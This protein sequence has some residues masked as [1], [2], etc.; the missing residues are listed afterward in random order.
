MNIEQLKYIVE[1]SKEES[2]T[3]AAKNLHISA[4]AVSQALREFE[5]RIN[6]KLFIR[7]KMKTVPTEAGKEI[8]NQAK[9]II[10]EFEILEEKIAIQNDTNQTQ[11]KIATP[12]GLVYL[13]NESIINFKKDFPKIDVQVYE[14]APDQVLSNIPVGQ[15]DI[16]FIFSDESKL[17][18]NKDV[19]YELLT[20]TKYCALVGKNSPL[21]NLD[22]VTPEDLLHENFVL[23]NTPS[24]VEHSRQI[25]KNMNIH[26][27]SNNTESIREAVKNGLGISFVRDITIKN[28]PDTFSGQLKSIP[29]KFSP[30]ISDELWT[31]YLKSKPLTKISKIFINYIQASIEN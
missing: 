15:P 27:I 21:Y 8:I 7:L 20:M 10:N 17:K 11:L 22:E 5:K 16:A 25:V 12:P 28:H 24:L 19:Q 14:Y 6:L 13:V 4:S 23:Y 2:I 18:E 29:L 9:K 30:Y 1:I 26:F 3:K 31:V